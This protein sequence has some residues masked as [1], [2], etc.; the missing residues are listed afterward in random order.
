MSHIDTPPSLGNHQRDSVDDLFT[1][2]SPDFDTP[3]LPQASTTVDPF[4]DSPRTSSRTSQT[5]PLSA[6]YPQ[7]NRTSDASSNSYSPPFTPPL[8]TT[9]R[10]GVAPSS[11]FTAPATTRPGP[12]PY[13]STTR[14]SSFQSSQSHLR[15]RSVHYD[16]LP[17]NSSSVITLPLGTDQDE[18]S[19]MNPFHDKFNKPFA[20]LMSNDGHGESEESLQHATASGMRSDKPEWVSSVLA[21]PSLKSAN[22][23]FFGDQLPTTQHLYHQAAMN[24]DDASRVL[25]SNPSSNSSHGKT[26]ARYDLAALSPEV[27]K[28]YQRTRYNSEADDKLHDMGPP[29]KRVGYSA[30][31]ME[32]SG[33]SGTILTTRGLLNLGGISILAGALLMLF[34]GYPVL[35]YFQRK[36]MSTY[37]ASGLGGTNSSGQVPAI[38]GYH[39][40]IDSDTPDSALTRTGFDGKHKISSGTFPPDVQ[41]F[42]SFAK[43]DFS[44][45]RYDPGNIITKDGFMELSLTKELNESSHGRGYLGELQIFVVG[46]PQLLTLP[47]RLVGNFV[48]PILLS[49]R[50][51]VS[52]TKAAISVSSLTPFYPSSE[53][54]ISL[55]G[56]TKAEGLWPAAWTMSNLGRAGYGGSLDGTWPYVYEECDVGTLANQTDPNTG[57]P[58]F[59]KAEGDQY[60]GYSFSYLGGQRLS[61]C[62]CEGEDHPGPKNS[63]GSWVGRGASEIDIFEATVSSG[64]GQISQ[65]GQWVNY[66]LHNAASL[67]TPALQAPF[68]PSYLFLNTSTDYVEYFDNAAN[69][70]ANTYLGGAYQQV[71]S[72]LSDTD[73]TTCENCFYTRKMWVKNSHLSPLPLDNSTTKFEKYGFEYWPSF[74]EGYGKG[75]ITFTQGDEE[76]WRISDT[77]MGPNAAAGIGE[78][79][80]TGEP[81]YILLN[82]GMSESFG[83]VQLDEIVFPSIMRVDYVRVYQAN[84]QIRVGCDP[85]D[86]PTADYIKLMGEA[87]TNP[88][89]T[90]LA[91]MGKKFP[92]NRLID[93]C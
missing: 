75:R 45:P 12:S 56:D 69:S 16:P 3:R 28:E 77:A 61:A 34:G 22:K 70:R 24:N 59:T 58:K 46:C 71:T 38:A 63:N 5:T 88:N 50:L 17:N 35:S 72:G 49:G 33:R 15:Q 79:V 41:P 10:A 31:V 76:M 19:G 54:A 21:H 43:A 84:D 92:K 42:R 27:M 55:P 6:N 90:V 78:R 87:Y 36:S 53:V 68:N 47:S 37:G 83:A 60:N 11:G 18:I 74:F 51:H 40:L 62:T 8:R 81:M 32:G 13:G 64:G 89:I 48:E 1:S 7:S 80:V 4:L 9:S 25:A 91:D 29:G 66:T 14:T 26:A 52:W 93:T 65:S 82:L 85:D 23:I 30:Y 86:H 2:H 39:G 20:A 73:V 44:S 67:L 57:L